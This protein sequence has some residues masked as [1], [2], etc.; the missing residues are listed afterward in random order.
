MTD[1]Q[2]TNPASGKLQTFAQSVLDAE[3]DAIRTIQLDA[4]FEQAVELIASLQGSL[5]ISGLGKSGLIGAKLSATFASTGTPSHVLHPVEAMHG[6]I[7]K[8]RQG[9]AVLLLSNGGGTEEVLTLA[10]LLKQDSIP[11]LALVGRP[12]S[13]LGRLADVTLAIGD[14]TEACPH[15]LAPSASTT[16][17]LALGDALALTVMRQRN[18]SADDFHKVHPSGGLG[19]QLMPVAQAMR[20]KCVGEDANMPLIALG[21]SMQDA[22]KLAE[23]SASDSGLRRAGALLVVEDTGKLAGIVTDG[24]LRSALIDQ[25]PAVWTSAIDQVMTKNPTTLSN[26]SLVRDAVHVV[27]S[28]RF[29]EIPIVDDLGRPLGIIDVQ[30]LAALKVIEG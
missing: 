13:E 19:K 30:D 26:E 12:G 11:T 24:D 28:K 8:V 18:F 1:P 7:G 10:T 27:R 17:M 5:V 4:S 16:A 25:G 21:T 15:N 20:F 23:Q 3:A 6:D 22:Y 29:D 9:D 14:I 2:P